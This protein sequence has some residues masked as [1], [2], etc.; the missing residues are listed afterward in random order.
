MNIASSFI[1][2]TWW[3]FLIPPFHAFTYWN[4]ASSHR[5]IELLFLVHTYICSRVGVTNDVTLVSE[6]NS[7][8]SGSSSESL[9]KEI[10]W[11]KSSASEIAHQQETPGR[12]RLESSSTEYENVH[13]SHYTLIRVLPPMDWW[14]YVHEHESRRK[15]IRYIFFKNTWLGHTLRLLK[16]DRIPPYLTSFSSRNLKNSIGN[17]FLNTYQTWTFYL[18]R[19]F[20]CSRLSTGGLLGPEG[21]R[22]Q[23]ES[24]TVGWVGLSR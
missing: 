4:V 16:M 19:R 21:P 5:E 3:E 17:T 11:R 24:K 7:H 10:E 22:S 6:I 20:Y 9:D 14:V 23:R 1:C 12:R 15:A 2:I 18:A 8:L 13:I